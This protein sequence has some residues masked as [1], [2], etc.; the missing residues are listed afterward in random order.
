MLFA[1]GNEVDR[2]FCRLYI[3]ISHSRGT[4]NLGDVHASSITGNE[5]FVYLSGKQSCIVPTNIVNNG[6]RVQTAW[7]RSYIHDIHSCCTWEK[8]T[9]KLTRQVWPSWQE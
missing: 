1:I 9:T 4:L 7:Q 2:Q 6:W 8:S 3:N 5:L